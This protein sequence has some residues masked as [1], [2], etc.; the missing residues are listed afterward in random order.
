MSGGIQGDAVSGGA[1]L[2]GF[3]CTLFKIYDLSYEGSLLYFDRRQHHW[4]TVYIDLQ[5]GEMFL[6]FIMAIQALLRY[7]GQFL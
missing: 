7:L 6:H 1:V 3:D 4:F 2:G 5:L